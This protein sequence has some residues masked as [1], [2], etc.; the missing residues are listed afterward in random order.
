MI[1]CAQRISRHTCSVSFRIP[2]NKVSWVTSSFLI[3]TLLIAVIGAPLYIWKFGLDVFQIGLF[4]FMTMATGFSITLG[5]HRLFS[6]LAFKAKWPVKLATLLFGAAAFENSVLMWSCEHRRHHKHV[7]QDEDPYDISK[8]FFWAHIGWLLFKLNPD[9]PYDN[10]LD[11][12]KDPLVMWQHRNVHL[13]AVVVGFVFPTLLGFFW[14]G[15]VGALGGFL[16]GGVL[17]VVFVQH[18][19]FFIN[20]ACHTIGSRPY[21]SRCSARDSW[22]MALF[23]FG[24]GYHNYHHEFQQDYRNGVKPWQFDP[25]KWI[26]W[27]LSKVGL[28]EGL[29]RVSEDRIL[30]AEITETRRRLESKLEHKTLSESSREALTLALHRL[31]ELTEALAQK[32]EDLI[33]ATGE[34][35]EESRELVAEAMEEIRREFIVIREMLTREGLPQLS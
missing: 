19:T 25:T 23:T 26:I 22:I 9:P 14:N 32:K 18:C 34:R 29:R 33:R 13:I 17:R 21:S 20:S 24:E 7:D 5:Y 12:K 27:L 2:F 1:P 3:G 8:G 15:W 4:L 6:H 10:V 35:F 30:L 16:L 31:H 11:L 28:A